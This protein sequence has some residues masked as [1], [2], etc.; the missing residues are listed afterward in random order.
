M[1]IDIL[2][3]R[4]QI[5]SQYRRRLVYISALATGPWNRPEI[6]NHPTYRGVG[7]NLVNFAIARSEALG[8]QGR[9]GLHSLPRALGFY[10]KLTI[11]LLDCGPDPEVPDN[12]VYFETIRRDS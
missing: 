6:N 1:M 5:E 9:I 3:K 7:R 12:L 4:C 10:S 8:Y 11:G 2:K